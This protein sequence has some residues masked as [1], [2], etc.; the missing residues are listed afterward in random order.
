MPIRYLSVFV[1][2]AE[3]LFYKIH[4][5]YLSNIRTSALS[6]ILID[7]FTYMSWLILFV[8]WRH[9]IIITKKEFEW[10]ATLSFAAG[11]V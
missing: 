5:N 10:I 9:L 11:L 4:A 8:G 7:M 1:Y 3:G 6:R 2:A